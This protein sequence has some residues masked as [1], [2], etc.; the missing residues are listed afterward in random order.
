MKLAD[1]LDHLLSELLG[2]LTKL[3][4]LLL[5][6][7]DHFLSCVG[8]AKEALVDQLRSLGWPVAV[9]PLLEALDHLR[10]KSSRC[11]AFHQDDVEV[12]NRIKAPFN[13]F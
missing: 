10:S 1:E 13:G 4:L 11:F 7:S 12:V 6:L 8:L 3:L 2:V 9:I 5:F